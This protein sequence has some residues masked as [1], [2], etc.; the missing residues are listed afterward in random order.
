MTLSNKLISI[1]QRLKGPMLA[2]VLLDQT[3][4]KRPNVCPNNPANF[5]YHTMALSNKQGLK[6]SNVSNLNP[7]ILLTLS[8]QNKD[9]KFPLSAF[10][11]L[12][13]YSPYQ[14]VITSK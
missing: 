4:A 1:K 12:L 11:T 14:G 13:S 2:K 3:K 9:L 8:H 5:N 7:T 10:L 6:I